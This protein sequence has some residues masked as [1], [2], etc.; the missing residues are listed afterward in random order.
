MRKLMILA[1]LAA[2]ACT[3]NEPSEAD[4][5]AHEAA[6]SAALAGYEADGPP[7]DCVEMLQLGGNKSAGEAIVFEG[8]TRARLWV[9]HAPGGCPDLNL[10]RA[11]QTR[12]SQARLCRGDIAT[13]FDPVSG[14]SYGSCGLGDFQPYR[15]VA[16]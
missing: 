15:R 3:M 9:N 4:R 1:T 8:K 11:L 6:L 10:G 12:T 5:S 13:V 14:M 16:R 7:V 2:A